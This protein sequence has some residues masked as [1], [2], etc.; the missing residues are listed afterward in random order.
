MIDEAETKFFGDLFLQGFQFGIDKFDHFAGFNIDQMIMV[1]FRC[2]LITGA[3]VS[4]VMAVKN[5]CFFEQTHRAIDC[6]DGNAGINGCGARM[7]RFHVW[8][9]LRVGQNPR[10][11][12]AL[13]GNPQALFVA[14][15][16]DIDVAGHSEKGCGRIMEPLLSRTARQ[17]NRPPASKV[18]YLRLPR[19]VPR[20]IFIASVRRC[21]A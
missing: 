16:L 3:T 8:V 1:G 7:Q 5:A 19:L 17:I 4:E 2:G 6:G 12:L 15:R 11:H 18:F 21:S 14:Q 10:Y 9:I 13:F 20:P